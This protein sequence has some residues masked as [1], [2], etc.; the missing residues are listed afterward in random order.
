MKTTLILL[1][2]L[3]ATLV[4]G[5]Q[6]QEK[7]TSH[8]I[9]K[10]FV[11]FEKINGDLDKDGVE[12]CVLIIKATD[13]SKFIKDE[14]RGELDRKR[15]GI[16]VLLNKK[17]HYELVAKNY[18]CF[19]SENEDGGVYFPPDLSIFIEKGNLIMHYGHGRY[20]YWKYTFRYKNADF[21]LIGYD[22]SN[23]GAVISNETSI[24]FLTKKKLIKENIN[25]NDE[26]GEEIFK[27]TWKNIKQN[28][29]IKLSKIND[30]DELYL[31]DYE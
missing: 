31:E 1:S 13:K 5:Q 27:E 10:G 17:D 14:N 26:G 8:F 22:N 11:L 15:R 6:K 16:I 28:P 19:S 18:T 23:G 20:G 9:P 4:F 24:N 21:D 30:F 29:L 2:T 7:K 3:F 25:K 12:D